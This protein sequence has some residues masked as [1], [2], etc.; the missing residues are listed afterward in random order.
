MPTPTTAFRRAAL[1]GLALAAA[2]LARPAGAEPADGLPPAAAQAP[3]LSAA[4][5]PDDAA[6]AGTGAEP[7]A[8]QTAQTGREE[9]GGPRPRVYWYDD[10]CAR[11][12]AFAPGLERRLDRAR[13][14]L[15]DSHRFP[16]A[17][18]EWR[19][20]PATGDHFFRDERGWRHGGRTRGWF[21]RHGRWH[22]DPA[23]SDGRYRP[24]RDPYSPHYEGRRAPLRAPCPCD[25]W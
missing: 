1:L 21:D 24:E 2:L 4:A 12:G 10:P 3:E 13:R 11:C 14:A 8:D 20:D 9:P 19:Q 18:L 6:R 23:W 16:P 7:T 17:P 25:R 5:A 22:P 15:D